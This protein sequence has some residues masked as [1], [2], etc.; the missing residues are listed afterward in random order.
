M[1]IMELL[2]AGLIVSIC[3]GGSN[4]PIPRVE[5]ESLTLLAY[6]MNFIFKVVL[7]LVIS[8]IIRSMRPRMR[9]D[10]TANFTFKVLIPIGLT[11]I[12]LIGCYL[13]VF[14]LNGWA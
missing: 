11:S 3:L 7:V 9:I 5:S 4:L 2:I 10:Q 13:G 12:L 14:G 1:R 6:T 8:A